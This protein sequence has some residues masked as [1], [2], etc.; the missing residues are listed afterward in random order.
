VRRKPDGSPVSDADERAQDLLVS[1]MLQIAPGVPIVAEESF[2][3]DMVLASECLHLLIDPLDGTKEFLAGRSDFTV[4]IAIVDKGAPLLGC[5]YAPARRRLYL[6]EA[7]AGAAIVRAGDRPSDDDFVR[8]H[9]R[10]APAGD[11]RAL[12][13][14]SHLE[15]RT[16][17]FLVA[18]SVARIHRLGSSLKF[19]L[20]AEGKAD[21]YPRLA[22]TMEWDTAAGHAVLNAAGG[23][24]L[25]TQGDPLRYGN[26]SRR[27]NGF[28]AWGTH[29]AEPGPP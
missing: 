8:I 21:L 4:N 19:C 9:T 12:V 1:S 5:V 23:A 29:P 7:G 25:T 13:S 3:Q 18:R 14:R 6:G 10:A 28:I 16:H 11:L 26:R 24:V 2:S 15:P 27:H 20:I 22:A 17:D